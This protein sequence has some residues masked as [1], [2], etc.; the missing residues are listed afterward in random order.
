MKYFRSM[1]IKF[2]FHSR[3]NLKLLP[4]TFTQSS[5]Y[6]RSELCLSYERKHKNQVHVL[7]K[8]SCEYEVE[9]EA[10]QKK[11]KKTFPQTFNI[12]VKSININHSCVLTL[13]QHCSINNIHYLKKLRET[14]SR[15]K[16]VNVIRWVNIP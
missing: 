3:A 12:T 2:F 5:F 11:I 13:Q 4:T 10:E 14:L 15:H 16:I 1:F 7:W 8:L 9:E 6:R